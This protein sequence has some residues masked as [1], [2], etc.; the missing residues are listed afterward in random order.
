MQEH[1]T[2]VTVWA[3]FFLELEAEISRVWKTKHMPLILCFFSV[4]FK[5]CHHH[6]VELCTRTSLKSPF[7]IPPMRDRTCSSLWIY[8]ISKRPPD[9]FWSV[10]PKIVLWCNRRYCRYSNWNSFQY[11]SSIS[12]GNWLMIKQLNWTVQN[13]KLTRILQWPSKTKNK[14]NF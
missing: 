6:F 7:L 11:I 2:P 9:L 13:W 3:Q 10:F 5:V 1:P 14:A 12:L 4:Y 8:V